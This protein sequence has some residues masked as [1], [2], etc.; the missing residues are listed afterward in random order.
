VGAID[1]IESDGRNGYIVTDIRSSKVLHVSA[2]G[3]VR[4]LLQLAG[5][6]ADLAVVPARRLA[7]VPHL[8]EN[9]VAAYD[10]SAALK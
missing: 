7:I 9:R 8:N 10:I 5:G 3:E 2:S 6:A 1:G 4:D